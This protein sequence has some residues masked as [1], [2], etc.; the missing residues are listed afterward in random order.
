MPASS[1]ARRT[2]ARSAGS[3][4]SCHCSPSS[5]MS[6]APAMTARDSFEDSGP[7][8]ASAAPFLRL[9]V[10]HLLCPDTQPS[11]RPLVLSALPAPAQ[12]VHEQ[13]VEAA[14]ARELGM[15]RRHQPVPLA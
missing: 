10:A 3:V 4:V 2:A 1:S 5:A 13:R 12:P 15:E 9:M 14:V 6:S 8:L 11:L 7:R